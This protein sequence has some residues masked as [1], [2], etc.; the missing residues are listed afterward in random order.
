MTREQLPNRRP[1][2]TLTFERDGISVTA[3]VGYKPDGTVGELFLNALPQNS[4][5]DVLLSDVAIVVSIALQYG[6][7]LRQL[8]HA[9]KRDVFGVASSHVGAALDRI[10]SPEV[11]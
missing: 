4:T 6:V 11:L 1:N 3:T 9:V 7:P 10:S 2:E 5:I 8:T